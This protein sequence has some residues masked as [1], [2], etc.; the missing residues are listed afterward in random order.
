MDLNYV[1]SLVSDINKLEAEQKVINYYLDKIEEEGTS[2][3]KKIGLFKKYSIEQME[4]LKSN[5]INEKMYYND[6]DRKVAE[7]GTDFYL[8]RELSFGIKGCTSIPKVEEVL[9]KMKLIESG[10]VLKTNLLTNI[11]I[12]YINFL[13]LTM[14]DKGID[15]NT[16]NKRT[17]EF[18]EKEEEFIKKRLIKTRIEINSIKMALILT[19]DWYQGLTQDEKKLDTFYYDFN[20]QTLVIKTDRVEVYY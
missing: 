17:R 20:G 7:K 16:Y 3:A 19:G 5:G 6:I 4:F 8:A 13:T 12:N 18:F 2:A 14:K 1:A 15:I 9:E 10:E 11:M